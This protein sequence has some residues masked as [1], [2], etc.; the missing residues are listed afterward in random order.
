MN[1]WVA[2]V[3][4]KIHIYR[5]EKKDVMKSL[6][7]RFWDGSNMLCAD[8]WKI[9][10]EENTI[11]EVKSHKDHSIISPNIMQ[12]VFSGLYEKD[13]DMVWNDIYE[14][15]IVKVK[16]NKGLETF[17][18]QIITKIGEVRFNEDAAAWMIQWSYNKNQ[19]HLYFMD[20][21]KEIEVIGNSF[22]NKDIELSEGSCWG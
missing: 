6:K 9:H 13:G 14:G 5:I 15:D 11:S 1:S 2:L 21:W 16:F 4:K 3:E 8:E 12:F 22:E 10:K 18:E 20:C 7:F 17:N 19:H